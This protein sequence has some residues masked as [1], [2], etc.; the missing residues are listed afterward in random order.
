VSP[1]S[2]SE[3]T[4]RK[5]A[6]PEAEV[7]PI[8]RLKSEPVAVKSEEQANRSA[9]IAHLKSEPEAP[10]FSE[11][12]PFSSVVVAID[13][14]VKP[15]IEP[16]QNLAALVVASVGP[17]GRDAPT[18]DGN[19]V[20]Q[21]DLN[22]HRDAA[23]AAVALATSARAVGESEVG[24]ADVNAHSEAVDAVD[25]AMGMIFGDAAL[26][27]AGA[28]EVGQRDASP[29]ADAAEVG[30]RDS[31]AVADAVEVG[32]RDVADAAEVGQRDAAAAADAAG[33]EQRDAAAVADAANVGQRDAAA[34]ADAAGVAHRDAVAVAVGHARG[35][36]AAKTGIS[37][38]GVALSNR[39]WCKVC[40]QRIIRY[41]P[42]FEY[43]HNKQKPLGYIH[44]ECV[45][46]SALEPHAL[47]VDLMALRESDPALKQAVSNA[48]AVLQAC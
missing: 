15:S 42:R 16:L 31:N 10:P 5:R 41:E 6:A 37:A 22:E 45:V 48:W 39:S 30:R 18:S 1:P 11:E 7:S 12:E 32:Q 21:V 2:P 36:R 27:A 25:A 40:T 35:C 43:R 14:A 26:D 44:V 19:E 33:V 9:T 38:V 47:I 17:S 8:K 3:S 20:G 24:Q 4:P 28:A 46:G 34:A 29:A 23:D 13:A